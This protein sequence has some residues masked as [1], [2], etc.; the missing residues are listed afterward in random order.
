MPKNT[1]N[2]SN[3]GLAHRSISELIQRQC[4]VITAA[5]ATTYGI[6]HETLRQRVL[7]GI[8]QRLL[9]AVFVL[10]AGP[11]S[12]LQ[13]LIAAQLYAGPGSMLTGRTALGVY[14][15]NPKC[16]G[17]PELEPVDI[18]VPHE[19]RRQ[20]LGCLRI[21]RTT[22]LPTPVVSGDL[23]L[24]PLSRA[25]VDSCTA[26]NAAAETG[27]NRPATAAAATANGLVAAVLAG[28]RLTIDE[29]ERELAT[30]PRRHTGDLRK[31][32]RRR[33]AD[34]RGAA[35]GTLID[36]LGRRGPF[37]AMRNVA[38]YAG[39]RRIARATALWPSRAVAASVDAPDDE[40]GRLADLG[41]AVVQISP[42]RV[43][44]DL[45]GVLKHLASVLMARP[46]ATF[47]AGVSVLLL[48]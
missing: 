28:G 27:S 24:A 11:A 1:W 14:G 5:Q 4:G 41:F 44:E 48:R 16:L 17:P 9:P 19:T 31:E 3:T 35:V 10:Q 30:A 39:R 47:P 40:T 37:G 26:L 32:L 20:N 22:R 13:W 25:A 36:A 12:R 45:T 34:E 18:L 46:E 8:W 21:T 2:S 15:V 6:A 38:I 33:R 43:T 23:R 7:R 42:Q 29:L